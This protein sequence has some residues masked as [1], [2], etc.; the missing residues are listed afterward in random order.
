VPE[1]RQPNLFVWTHTKQHLE[2]K[3]FFSAATAK[4]KSLAYLD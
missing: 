2:L 4:G 3:G 1:F